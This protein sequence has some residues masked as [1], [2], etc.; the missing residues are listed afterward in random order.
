M[1]KDGKTADGKVVDVVAPPKVDAA[2]LEGTTEDPVRR[3]LSAPWLLLTFAFVQV[4]T[5]AH[6]IFLFVSSPLRT[7]LGLTL[8]R[9]ALKPEWSRRS[10]PSRAASSTSPA[11]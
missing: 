4:T 6:E 5:L 9:T 10:T 2:P 7:A 11:G 3:L 1:L 8:L